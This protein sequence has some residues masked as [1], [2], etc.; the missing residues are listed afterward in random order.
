MLFIPRLF[1]L[2]ALL[3][4]CLAPL[5]A[6]RADS[7]APAITISS[8]AELAE[9]A[10][11]DGQTVTMAPGVY[12]FSDYTP[13]SAIAGRRER[14]EFA[15][16]D[17]SGSGNTFRLDGVVIEFDTALRAALRAPIHNNEFIVTGN[18]NTIRG[19]TITCLG[20]GTSAAG[21]L[22]CVVGDG[23]TVRD[24]TFTVRG[25]FPYAYGD[26]FGKGGKPVIGHR[27]HSGF[28]ITGS[29]TRVIGCKLRMRSFGHGF[30]VQGGENH[31]FEDCYVEGEMRASDAML[32]ETSGPAF[33]K[34]FAMEL[35]NREGEHR[36]LPGY[37]KSLAE[38]GF[39]TYGQVKNLTFINCVAKNMRGGF[40]LR[41]REPVRIVNC[42]AIGN[43]RG[44]WTSGGVIENSRGDAEFGPLLFVEGDGAK[45]DLTLLPTESGA[46]IHALATI[47]GSGHDV[48]L[49]AA[50][51]KNRSRPLPILI[52]RGQPPAGEGMAAISERPARDITLRNETT[53]PVEIAAGATNSTTLTRGPVTR[54]EGRAGEITMLP[55]RGE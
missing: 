3:G 33:E 51:G 42:A 24:C 2:L 17:F 8:L 47:H 43:E 27:K 45:I 4:L 20:D 44:F 25:S 16:L 14:K 55:G 41:T 18:N 21:A 35:R 39:R 40:E 36:V 13:L 6:A 12:R 19:L 11:R 34:K 28:L 38:D 49:R 48:T 30:F 7:A 54:N 29:N 32:A 52:G 37:M 31:H 23:N 10:T 26:L 9:H 53:M 15:F 1:S 5:S 46:V 22:V 50:D